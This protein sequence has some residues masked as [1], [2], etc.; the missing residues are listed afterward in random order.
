MEG[1]WISPFTLG[2]F[3]GVVFV[4]TVIEWLYTADD[5]LKLPK[6]VCSSIGG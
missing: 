5:L 2:T 6:W 3:S 1:N 4:V